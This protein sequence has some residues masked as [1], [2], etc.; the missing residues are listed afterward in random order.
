MMMQDLLGNDDVKKLLAAWQARQ[1]G[2]GADGDGGEGGPAWSDQPDYPQKQFKQPFPGG[3]F[4]P[5]QQQ[6]NSVDYFP[7]GAAM[8]PGFGKEWPSIDVPEGQKRAPAAQQPIT[9]PLPPTAPPMA[10]ALMDS[11]ATWGFK[12][13]SSPQETLANIQKPVPSPQSPD[14]QANAAPSYPDSGPLPQ[15]KINGM[16]P[17]EYLQQQRQ[18]D[19]EMQ[20]DPAWQMR[21]MLAPS[22]MPFGATADGQT[23]A[24][25]GLGPLVFGNGNGVGPVLSGDAVFKEASSPSADAMKMALANL[26]NSGLLDVAKEH[27]RG[28]VDAAKLHVDAQDKARL[29]NEDLRY[30]DGLMAQVQTGAMSQQQADEALTTRKAA[31]AAMAPRTGGSAPSVS[32]VSPSSIFGPASQAGATKTFLDRFNA[33]L[34]KGSVTPSGVVGA[35]Q[36]GNAFDNPAFLSAALPELAKKG[37]M[38]DF[39]K[40]VAR[41][42]AKYGRE[43]AQGDL[44]VGGFNLHH[45]GGS[46]YSIT[47]PQG[48]SLYSVPLD[49][50][51][52][53]TWGATA[54]NALAP[55]AAQKNADDVLRYFKLLEAYRQS[56]QGR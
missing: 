24:G 14:W 9:K 18:A 15:M 55:G 22:W 56:Q 21:R 28:Q 26:H 17:A 30:L 7:L 16:S 33:D 29:Q 43:L 44:N 42:G 5:P 41:E 13:D 31:R 11:P 54:W 20:N 48:G 39:M 49:S 47:N 45:N 52:P 2:V 35:L 23:I 19:K 10:Q 8:I 38:D 4:I 36:S 32:P 3:P 51:S 40:Q 27:S 53:R 25:G 37:N 6:N 46:R 34:A 12:G 1:A 50:P